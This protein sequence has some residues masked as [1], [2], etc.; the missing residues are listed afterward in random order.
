MNCND[1]ERIAPLLG[2]SEDDAFKKLK[3]FENNGLIKIEYREGKT[4]Y[5]DPSYDNWKIELGY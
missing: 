1:P 5:N 4:I 3:E 2:I